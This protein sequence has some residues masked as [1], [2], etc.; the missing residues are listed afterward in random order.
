MAIGDNLFNT[1]MVD[2]EDTGTTYGDLDNRGHLVESITT[3]NVVQIDYC[4]NILHKLLTSY[5]KSMVA[6]AK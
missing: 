5:I 6:F 2:E 3:A 4:I 1:H